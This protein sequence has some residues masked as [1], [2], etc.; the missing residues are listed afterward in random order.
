MFK[1]FKYIA[2]AVA[3]L[4]FS[5][6]EAFSQFPVCPPGMIFLNGLCYYPQQ[7]PPPV[8]FPP[9]PTFPPGAGPF[10]RGSQQP[11]VFLPPVQ[12]L[13]RVVPTVAVFHVNPVQQPHDFLSTAR[14]C[15]NNAACNAALQYAATSVGLPP[16]VLKYAG[17][18]NAIA[19][20]NHGDES[21]YFRLIPPQGHS[22]CGVTISTTSIVPF[23]GERS[24]RFSITP[25]SKEVNIGIWL[26]VRKLGQG[27]SWYDGNI[28][29]LSIPD[30][31]ISRV[32]SC[33]IAQ[34]SNVQEWVCRGGNGAKGRPGC[35]SN[36]QLG[37]FHP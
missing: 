9:A 34:S 4:L 30:S 1:R 23:S 32:R 29:V 21:H 15:M 26:P 18:I 2:V 35:G 37:S 19:S 36:K 14:Q 12:S 16:D 3:T 5:N 11:P 13:Q 27:R 20:N 28:S 10:Q 25:S 7:L 33:G 17:Y 24:A 22:I 6:A 31:Q 8:V